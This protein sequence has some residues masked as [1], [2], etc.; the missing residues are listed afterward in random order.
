LNDKNTKVNAFGGKIGIVLAGLALIII[1]MVIVSMVNPPVPT[2]T[3]VATTAPK[4][5]VATTKPTPSPTPAPVTHK[6]GDKV[7]AGKFVLTV[8]SANVTTQLKSDYTDVKTEDQFVVVKVAITNNDEKARDVSTNMFT[9]ADGSGK[10]YKAYDRSVGVSGD[11]FLFYETINPGLSRTRSVAFETPKGIA[12][13]KL[14]ANSG[15][16]LAGGES[17]TVDLGQ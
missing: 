10:T 8:T 11:E 5:Y 13:L 14:I 6:I 4:S 3:A 16:A 2:K 12:G 7:A 9:L 1:A 15:V 17:V